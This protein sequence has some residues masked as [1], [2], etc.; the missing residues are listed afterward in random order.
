MLFR[1]TQDRSVI[2]KSSDKRTLWSTGEGY[3]S[4]LAGKPMDSM[5]GQKSNVNDIITPD[6]NPIDWWE[7][8]ARDRGGDKSRHR[9]KVAICQPRREAWNTSLPQP[10]KEPALPTP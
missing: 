4:I 3:F 1:A 6:R 5:K 9:E 7:I 2:E 10:Q 8:W